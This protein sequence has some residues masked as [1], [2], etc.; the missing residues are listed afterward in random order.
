M[1]EKTG[2]SEVRNDRVGTTAWLMVA[3]FVVMGLRL[4]MLTWPAVS[5]TTESRHAVI[6]MRMAETGDWVTP[7]AYFHGRLVPFWGKP[8]LQFWLTAASFRLLGGSEWTARLPGYL[9]GL[10][11]LGITFAFARRFW[12][13]EA[14]SA[15]TAVLASS[16]LF[17]GL[18]GS[19]TLDITLAASSAA[20]ISSSPATGGR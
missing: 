3:V 19:V 20:A 12:T 8:P 11:M 7:R 9:A 18:A 17:F 14:A 1:T 4:A 5:D 15:S 10:A 2:P 13:R 6:A 16:L